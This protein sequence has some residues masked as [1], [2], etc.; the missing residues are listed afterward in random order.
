MEERKTKTTSVNSS[1]HH[2]H[3]ILRLAK[4]AYTFAEEG[5]F[6]AN[7][8]KFEHY[9]GPQKQKTTYGWFLHYPKT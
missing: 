9:R 7:Y 4:G 1:T 8:G 2:N 6:S 5:L 3:T